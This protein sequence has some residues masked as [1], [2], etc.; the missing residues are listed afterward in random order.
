LKEF[1]IE[2]LGK[3]QRDF[4][5]FPMERNHHIQAQMMMKVDIKR[6]LQRKTETKTPIKFMRQKVLRNVRAKILRT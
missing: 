4:Q 6:K 5:E 3:L 1:E 2:L